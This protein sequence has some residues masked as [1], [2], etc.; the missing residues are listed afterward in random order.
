MG[1]GQGG[2][3]R[4]GPLGLSTGEDAGP[5]LGP[6]LHLVGLGGAGDCFFPDF[7]RGADQGLVSAQGGH[8][9]LH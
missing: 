5:T 7:D 8:E 3:G 6:V 9:F 1:T 2:T 4:W